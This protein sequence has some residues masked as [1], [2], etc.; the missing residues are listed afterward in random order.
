[1]QSSDNVFYALYKLVAKVFKD[2]EPSQCSL[3]LFKPDET[4]EEGTIHE[5]KM[6]S[7]GGDISKLEKPVSTFTNVYKYRSSR[8]ERAFVPPTANKNSQVSPSDVGLTIYNND[9]DYVNSKNF[10]S[11]SNNEQCINICETQKSKKMEENET[12]LSHNESKLI[13]DNMDLSKHREDCISRKRKS[14][15]T[16]LSLKVKCIQGNSNRIKATKIVR[17]K[18]K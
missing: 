15:A 13:T 8:K 9:L 1:M 14:S 5:V 12:K 2:F 16:Y 3:Q 18:K 6:I 11:M 17:R 4:C 10:T 7:S